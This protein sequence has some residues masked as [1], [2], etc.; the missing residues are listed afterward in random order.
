VIDII[1]K[2]IVK[3]INYL[4][5]IYLRIALPVPDVSPRP[6]PPLSL[7]SLLLPDCMTLAKNTR[8]KH[9]RVITTART[10]IIQMRQ[11]RGYNISD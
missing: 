9:L 6:V 4:P 1:C 8:R 3:M 7:S 5:H 10:S 2:Y 11:K